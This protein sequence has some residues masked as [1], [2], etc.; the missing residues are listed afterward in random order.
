MARPLPLCNGRN[1]GYNHVCNGRNRVSGSVPFI[2]RVAIVAL[3][4]VR[5]AALAV[6]RRRRRR[7]R[8]ASFRRRGCVTGSV[9]APATA[10]EGIS[11]TSP[12]SRQTCGDVMSVTGEESESES[13]EY[14]NI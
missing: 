14:K 3:V 7:R 10:A 8:R 2:G 6:R 1:F 5:C 11:I 4:T 13:E 12:S 9:Q